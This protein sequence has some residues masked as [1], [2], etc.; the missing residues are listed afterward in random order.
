MTDRPPANK[1]MPWVIGAVVLAGAV[2]GYYFWQQSRAPGPEPALVAAPQV[3]PAPPAEPEKHYPAPLVPEAAAQPLPE[4]DGSDQHLQDALAT[5]IGV[6]PF[7]KYLVPQ[8]IVRHIVVTID[9][10]PRKTLALR[11]SPVKP[12]GGEFRTTGQGAGLE[13]AADNA[14]RYAPYV[15]IAALVNAKKLVAT[16]GR[17]YPLFQ[18][19][20]EDLG[21]PKGY[22][23]DRLIVVIDH[24]LAAPDAIGPI[25][26]VTP[27]VQH[28]FADPELEA[29]SAG[30]KILLRMGTEN[31][32]VI[33]AKLREIRRELTGP[34]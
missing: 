9:N 16:Y 23:N 12:V 14:A 13:I 6:E 11:L 15:R 34:Q 20:Y 19:A 1:A 32:A 3:A 10:L 7:S 2:A 26:L 31:A 22:F 29:R 30:Q 24:L 17:L 33:K 28:Q 18:K 8:E 5:L 4:L 21:Y 27:H 25:K